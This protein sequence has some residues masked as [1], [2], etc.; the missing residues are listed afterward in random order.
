MIWQMTKSQS[1]LSVKSVSELKQQLED[2]KAA[3]HTHFYTDTLNAK[4][5]ARSDT[6]KWAKTGTQEYI[7][8]YQP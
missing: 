1:N 8:I 5:E 6:N 3:H 4:K 7:A 2:P